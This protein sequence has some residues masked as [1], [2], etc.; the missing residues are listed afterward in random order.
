MT[1]P[2]RGCFRREWNVDLFTPVDLATLTPNA[3]RV[4]GEIPRPVE[5]VPARSLKLRPRVPAAAVIE[6][7][8]SQ[9]RSNHESEHRCEKWRDASG[10]QRHGQRNH[11]LV[12]V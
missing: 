1:D 8:G 5:G 6:L 4:E 9:R 3:I 10:A 11:Q 7:L 2:A 12:T